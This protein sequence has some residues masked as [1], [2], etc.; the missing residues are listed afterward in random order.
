MK[1][2]KRARKFGP[3][4]QAA[5]VGSTAGGCAILLLATGPA[6]RAQNAPDA[7]RIASSD[8]TLQE[9]VVTGI[10]KSIE[11][12]VTAKKNDDRIIEEVSTEDIGK[13]PDASI[14][15]SIARLPGLAA[16]RTNGRAQTLDIR[17]MG[18]DFT[19]TLLNGREQASVNDNRT[20]EFDQYPSELVNAVKVYKTPDAGMAYQGI[21]GTRNVS[22]L[23]C[24]CWKVQYIRIS[25]DQSQAFG[26]A[27]DKHRF[28]ARRL[29][30]HPAS[31]IR[32]GILRRVNPRCD[33]NLMLIGRQH[34]GPAIGGEILTFGIGDHQSAGFLGAG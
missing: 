21:A 16:Q 33:A 17:G 7:T 26:G 25:T 24:P 23:T 31:A 9:V 32:L 1:K 27:G 5:V 8:Q 22:D 14:A 4:R 30:R 19:V 29:Q 34:R 3:R 18:P 6:A 20:V 10:R 2:S 11:D 13:L 12:T 15:E 28:P